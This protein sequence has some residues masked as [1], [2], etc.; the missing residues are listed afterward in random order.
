M[1]GVSL[2][3]QADELRLLVRE[4]DDYCDGIAALVSKGKR[5]QH[6]LDRKRAKG[7]AYRAAAAT[8]AALERCADRVRPI[9]VESMG[10]VD[11]DHK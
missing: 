6:E 8:L 3:E 9:I 7:A 2:K 5:P 10:G 1:S 11:A 4:H